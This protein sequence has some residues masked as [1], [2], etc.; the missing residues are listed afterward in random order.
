MKVS[1]DKGK[2]VLESE[3]ELVVVKLLSII[4]RIRDKSNLCSCYRPKESNSASSGVCNAQ[5]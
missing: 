5:F 2:K 1:V 3:F 4:S